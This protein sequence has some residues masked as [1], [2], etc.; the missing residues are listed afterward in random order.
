MWKGSSARNLFRLLFYFLEF[1]LYNRNTV[2]RTISGKFILFFFLECN[3]S[4]KNLPFFLQKLRR[5][6]L[7]IYKLELRICLIIPN[8]S[9]NFFPIFL[10]TAFERCS[11]KA[12]VSQNDVIKYS[13]SAPGVKSRKALHANLLKI[14]LYHWY[15]TN[16]VTT[17]SEQRY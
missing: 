10:E 6:A 12:V 1:F 17:S 5:S 8:V 4:N 11:I 15:F 13:S 16:N 2:F 7:V 3:V 9:L 14:A